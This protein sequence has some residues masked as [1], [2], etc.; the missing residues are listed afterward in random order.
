[1]KNRSRVKTVKGL[2]GFVL[3]AAVALTLGTAAHADD[4]KDDP[5]IV[6]AQPNSTLSQLTIEGALFGYETPTV[7]FNGVKLTVISHTPTKVVVT[8]PAGL[9]PAT[10]LLTLTRHDK[11]RDKDSDIFDVTVGTSGAVGP[12]GPAGPPGP[13]GPPGPKGDTGAQGAKGDTGAAM[14]PAT[15]I[16][17]QLLTGGLIT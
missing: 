3:L 6:K 11:G 16:N 4:D 5:V 14:Q 9:P 13:V 8:L 17:L 2:L 1:M 15:S 12:Q 7:T 10:Y